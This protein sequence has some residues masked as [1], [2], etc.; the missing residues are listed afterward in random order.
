MWNVSYKTI[1]S[2]ILLCNKLHQ[3]LSA[4][5]ISTTGK[6]L[7][8]HYRTDIAN[9][10]GYKTVIQLTTHVHLSSF[11]RPVGTLYPCTTDHFFDSLAYG[12]RSERR[13]CTTAALQINHTN[14]YVEC[15]KGEHLATTYTM[16]MS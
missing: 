14:H 6:P 2:N 7:T 10:I 5:P 11:P 13:R 9:L 16:K 4:T 15:P 12:L 1:Y 8:L 3:F